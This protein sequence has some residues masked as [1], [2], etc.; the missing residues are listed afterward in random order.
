MVIQ[1]T[2]RS[3]EKKQALRFVQITRSILQIFIYLT[4][5]IV[6]RVWNTLR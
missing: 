4:A 1:F 5:A 2:V 6:A 3:F